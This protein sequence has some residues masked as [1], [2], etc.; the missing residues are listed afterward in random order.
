M[1]WFRQAPSAARNL[2]EN[3]SR[4]S[5]VRIYMAWLSVGS[6][7][8]DL[9]FVNALDAAASEYKRIAAEP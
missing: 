5:E 9:V 3:R 4:K 1:R 8:D 7:V 6:G 2:W